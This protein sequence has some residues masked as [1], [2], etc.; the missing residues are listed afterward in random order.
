MTQPARR[1]AAQA[2]DTIHSTPLSGSGADKV[3][4]IE[5]YLAN[6][7]YCIVDDFVEVSRAPIIP[8]GAKLYGRH[9]GISGLKLSD[10]STSHEVLR[11]GTNSRI[12]NL[13]LDGNLA[14]RE[15]TGAFAPG[16]ADPHGYVFGLL[17][18]NISGAKAKDCI[19]QDVGCTAQSVTD[20]LPNGG[21]SFMSLTAAATADMTG[22]VVKRFKGT[23]P[24]A[25]F[26]HRIFSPFL[27]N[28]FVSSAFND[29][30][31]HFAT[32]NWIAECEG[33]DGLKNAIEL[34]G[35]F[36]RNNKVMHTRI[37]DYNGQGGIEADFGAHFNWFFGNK[38]H[39]TPSFQTTISFAGFNQNRSNGTDGSRTFGNRF[40]RCDVEMLGYLDGAFNFSALSEAGQSSNAEFIAC[41]L[42]GP[43]IT[44]SF[45][46]NAGA[47][48]VVAYY[49]QDASIGKNRNTM[50][51]DGR[52]Y[53]PDRLVKVVGTQGA[54][55]IVVKDTHGFCRGA[56]YEVAA[57]VTVDALHL[58]G[59]SYP[60]TITGSLS[61]GS[62][63]ITTTTTDASVR[64]QTSASTP[65]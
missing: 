31:I 3:G 51:R 40:E 14:T 8:T 43:S 7:G 38:L 30:T 52:A 20:S 12:K 46:R 65:I 54:D 17:F 39:F 59:D 61:T 56:V 26:H 6:R 16:A 48:G 29:N 4:Q 11:A 50:I 1:L 36:T 63:T 27:G 45:N 23:A 10:A 15:A 41:H 44:S 22:N 32:D 18:Q 28:G 13:I 58:A 42:I 2:L 9:Y 47:T 33:V 64:T 35:P 37:V 49:L 25:G 34:V 24:K 60:Q 53:N 62:G 57:G 5:W 19:Y 55:L 21:G